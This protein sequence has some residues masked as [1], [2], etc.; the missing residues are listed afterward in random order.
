LPWFRGAHERVKIWVRKHV[1]Y[2][3]IKR[4]SDHRAVNK[5]LKIIY[6]DA[7]LDQR[8]TGAPL[9]RGEQ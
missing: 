2:R 9:S 5:A 6:F 1:C 7:Q 8:L 4:Q 3:G